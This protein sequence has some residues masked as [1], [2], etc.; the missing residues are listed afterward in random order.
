MSLPI[1]CKTQFSAI[2]WKVLQLWLNIDSHLKQFFLRNTKWGQKWVYFW[3]VVDWE[4]ESSDCIPWYKWIIGTCQQ[5][6][7]VKSEMLNA[8]IIRL[9]WSYRLKVETCK[10]IDHVEDEKH[11]LKYYQNR[12]CL[13]GHQLMLL[14]YLKKMIWLNLWIDFDLLVSTRLY[15]CDNQNNRGLVTFSFA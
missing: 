11:F 1:F 5:I 14:L 9:W 15:K 13:Y 8:L 10:W 6:I 7:H 2:Y 3:G 12:F 4:C